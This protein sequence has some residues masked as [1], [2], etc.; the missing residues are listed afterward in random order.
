[1]RL[2]FLIL[3]MAGVAGCQTPNSLIR[4]PDARVA[5]YLEKHPERPAALRDAL[6]AG[7]PYV[8]MTR[9]E[10]IFCWGKPDKVETS[11]EGLNQEEVWTYTTKPVTEHRM[12]WDMVVELAEVVF[13]GV[14]E[15]LVVTSS[16]DFIETAAERAAAAPPAPKPWPKLALT[17]IMTQ[18]RTKVAVL[19]GK[20]LPVGG[21]IQG[22][23]VAA[24]EP[25]GVRL[26]FNQQTR[27]LKTG[28][29][30]R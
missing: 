10:V 21:V 6:T 5:R 12:S 19:N 9:Q 2:L 26:K 18:G 28:A 15:D 16:E 8:G 30:T 1:M 24:I 20:L 17:G 14:G 22:V 27:F 23:T 4:D 7:E 11:V 25:N 29:S 13:Q 3:M